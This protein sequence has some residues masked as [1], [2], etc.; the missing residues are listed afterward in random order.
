MSKMVHVA[1]KGGKVGNPKKVIIRAGKK[2]IKATALKK[3]S[4][5]KLKTKLYKN[6]YLII[7]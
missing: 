4:T 5:L 1:T 3:G 2:A 6:Y 7:I